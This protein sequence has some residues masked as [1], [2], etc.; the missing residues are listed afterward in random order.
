MTR[1]TVLKGAAGAAALGALGAPGAALAGPR[2]V[3]LWKTAQRNGIVY[4]SSW[5]TWES[6]KDYKQLLAR[7][8]AMLLTEDDL[9]WYRVKPSRDAPLDFSYGDKLVAFAERHNQLVLGAHLVWDEGFGDGWGE[10]ELWNLSAQ[11]AKDLL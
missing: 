6:D 7:E 4:G 2:R 11:E 10:D 9:L 8:A 5:A 1:R 3:P